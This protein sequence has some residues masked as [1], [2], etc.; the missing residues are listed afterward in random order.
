MQR[1]A[2]KQE[3]CDIRKTA[4][5][6]ALAEVEVA[7][8]DTTSILRSR[9][10]IES[11]SVDVSSTRMENDVAREWIEMAMEDYF[12]RQVQ[13]GQC[14]EQLAGE[15]Y[16]QSVGCVVGN[17]EVDQRIPN[18][19]IP[20]LPHFLTLFRSSGLAAACSYFNCVSL[21]DEEMRQ[22]TSLETFEKDRMI[23]LKVETRLEEIAEKRLAR[24]T[25]V[26]IKGNK[27]FT[28]ITRAVHKDRTALVQ[29]VQDE[30][31]HMEESANVNVTAASAVAN[32]MRSTEGSV[33][34]QGGSVR[35]DNT[36]PPI[37]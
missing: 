25:R 30:V 19:V 15:C 9:L 1:A 28:I 34:P 13:Y 2:N 23:R 5:S 3:A 11:E 27:R 24:S 6:K 21:P 18:R 37:K 16:L 8:R 32:N 33:V 29:A 35:S 14:L 20:K 17:K 36:L 22:R 26:R 31:A 4:V 7:S 10:A 12:C